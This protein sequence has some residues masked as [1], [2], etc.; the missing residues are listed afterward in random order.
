M[1]PEDRL[2]F[3]CARQVML[4]EHKQ[5]VL[6]LNRQ[7]NLSWE[8]VFSKAE[9]HGIA[10]LVYINLCQRNDLDINI[11]KTTSERYH[12][13]LLR[14]TIAK[15][16]RAQK[17]VEV[18]AYFH[19]KS[20][21]VLLFKGGVLDL[22]VYENPALV[23]TKDFDLILRQTRDSFTDSELMHLMDYLHRTSI[24]YDFYEH[25]DMSI[26]GAL[27][28]DFDQIWQDAKTIDYRGQPVYIMCPEDMFISLCINSCRKRFFQLKSMMDIAETLRVEQ[29]IKW[30]LIVEKA[31]AY[32]CQNIV[33]T[34]ILVT[35]LTLGCT[36]PEDGIERL[37][38]NK[39]RA[40]LIKS[41]ISSLIRYTAIPGN[42]NIM[43]S[44]NRRPV[45]F[46]LALPYLTY[47]GYQMRHKL[48]REVFSL[49][50]LRD[51][52]SQSG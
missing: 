45:D 52:A 3:A 48:F 44:I 30:G 27:R 28:I 19:E 41:A 34:A 5:T 38:V 51:P 37:G 12:M 39:M 33:Y 25:H 21:D 35:N 50:R 26:N 49:S 9:Q 10:P 4:E 13:V 24:E 46:S 29:D 31:I 2:L 1:T 36:L 47:K 40:A 32:D 15:E 11:P 8:T 7:Y 20:I 43:T 22:L 16:R 23:A 18:L 17:L 6:E 42:L 14:N